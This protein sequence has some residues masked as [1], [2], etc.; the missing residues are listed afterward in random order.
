LIVFGDEGFSNQL[1]KF[2]IKV[3]TEGNQNQI[4]FSGQR[5]KLDDASIELS[6]A[7]A[8]EDN[9]QNNLP[10]S[11]RGRTKPWWKIPEETKGL[12]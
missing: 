4:I 5:D 6:F 2:I 11:L 3:K 8:I 9:F 12:D 10:K 1:F 7:Q